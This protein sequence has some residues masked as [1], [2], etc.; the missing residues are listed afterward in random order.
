MYIVRIEESIERYIMYKKILSIIVTIGMA[1]SLVAA[2]RPVAERSHLN[3]K[4]FDANQSILEATTPDYSLGRVSFPQG[5]YDFLSTDMDG[6]MRLIGAPDLPSTSTFLAV[7]ASGE[8]QLDISYTSFS[9]ESN[10]DLAPF[11]PVQL[12]AEETNADFSINREIYDTDA[13]FPQSPAILHERIQLRDLTLVT[14]EVSPF[15]YNPV[16]KELR[17]YEGLEVSVNHTEPLTA[18]ERP[19]SRFFE[20]IYQT[21]IPNSTLVLEPNYQ[22][23]S[24]LFVYP[25]N[26]SVLTLL[27]SLMDWRHEKGFE[28][29]SASTL[30]TGTSNSSIK[31]YI[32]TAYD[33]WTN[34]PEFVVLVGDAGGAFNIPTW[35]ENFSNY[36]GEGDLPYVHLAGSDYV[37]DAF[38]GRIPFESTSEFTNILSKILNYEKNPSNFNTTWYTRAL[39]VGDQASSGL[40]TIMTNRNINE[41]MEANGYENNFQVYSGSFVS[42]I[43]SSINSG[44]SFFNYR[45]W[46][47]MSGWGNSNTTSLTNGANLPFVTILTCGT[48]SFTGDARSE[49]FLKVGTTSVPKGAIAAVGTATSG[50]HTLYNNCVSVG[51]Y[52]GIFSDKIY[53]AGSALERGRLNLNQTYPSPTNNY[54]KIFSHWNNLMGDPATELWTGVPANIQVEVSAQIPDDAMYLDVTTLDEDDNILEDAWVTLTGSGVFVSGYSDEDGM[55]VLDL[56]DVLPPTLK[57]T[58][59][60][61]N[62]KPRQMDITVGNENFAVLI[63][64]ATLTETIGNSNGMLN[65]GETAQF[66]LTFSNHSD[67]A[68]SNVSVTVT[69]ENAEP[70]NYFYPTMAAGASIIVNN[71]TFNLPLDYPSI[72]KYDVAIEVN[73]DGVSLYSDHRRF[74]VYAPYLQVNTLGEPGLPPYSFDPGEVADV[75]LYCDNIGTLASSNLT[76]TLRS[77]DPNVEVLDSVAVFVDAEAGSA[78]NNIASTFE[79]DL[80]TQLTIGVQIPMQVEFTDDNG[81]VELVNLLLPIGTPGPGDPTGPDVG[82]Y[83]CYDSQDL[84]YALAPQYNWIEIVPG[85]GSYT[86]TLVPLND[87]GN[88][89]ED[90]VTMN[91]PFE[92]GFYGEDYNQVSICSNGYI[93]LGASEVALFRNYQMPGPLGPNPMIAAFWDDLRMG[94]GDVYTYYNVAEHF[95]VIEYHNMQNAFSNDLEKFE[96]ILYDADYYGSTDG[97]GDIKIQ[98]HT[99]NNNNTG[100][101]AS[102]SHGQ[103]STIGIEDHTGQLGIQYTFNNM[104]A[105]TANVLTD[106]SA[107][108]FTTRTD[109]ILPCPGWGRGDI[110]N[111]GYRGVQDLVILINV[112]LGEGEFGECEFWAADKSLDSLIDIS[113]VVLLVD[114]IMGNNLARVSDLDAGTADFVID[115]GSLSLRASS[116]AEGF[117]FT[118]NSDSRVNFKDYPGLS[119]ASRESETGLKVIGY[120]TGEAR[121][122]FEILNAQDADFSISSPQVAG[123]AG[124]LMKSSTTIIPERFEITS[125]YPNPFN[126]S[127]TISYELPQAEEVSIR[128]F[129]ALGQEVAH[130]SNQLQAG[131]HTFSWNGLDQSNHLVSSGIYFARI[132]TGSASQMVKLTYLR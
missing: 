122:E 51:I 2:S 98:Y 24:I 108:F 85:M 81:F 107:I 17:I 55:V 27:Q 12:E 58:V 101:S 56:P 22:V 123:A 97:N 80:D 88:N 93:A 25:D 52:H 110:N 47:G 44:V 39:L 42:Q 72:G 45:G 106:E 37:A 82:G 91:L 3:L 6:Q 111:D 60:K 132:T 21:M 61:H 78:T 74:D 71:L 33:T 67:V 84:A 35:T 1:T 83:F 38:V 16:R 19:I 36:N 53:Y 66:D 30:L 103:Y 115:N 34:P 46:L 130:T 121:S 96:I 120:W 26:S 131:S 100:S 79:I 5:D 124:V 13:W 57:L 63:D 70:E 68:I 31:S 59:T 105:E 129:N 10:V 41:Y 128:I 89:Q 62:F 11:Q 126:P 99:F 7:P 54:V 15:Q 73:S 118:L 94:S 64:A 104:W 113:D 92:F 40:S 119:L 29:H 20:P 77:F 76:A 14:V 4:S 114:E 32:Q 65:P 102:S 50:T 48:G 9:V 90:I 95:F 75:V 116:P 43:A 127:V 69:G 18:P 112:M 49:E 23:P 117:S 8:L 125:V 28:V 109:A 86:G 87:N